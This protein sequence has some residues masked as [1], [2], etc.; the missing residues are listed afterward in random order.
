MFFCFRI[1]KGKVYNLPKIMIRIAW[2]MKCRKLITESFIDIHLILDTKSLLLK[3]SNQKGDLVRGSY[4]YI[5]GRTGSKGC[6]F[7][8]D[9]L[10]RTQ[11]FRP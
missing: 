5:N 10:R 2:V 4:N 7:K 8:S 3:I 11:C 6:L 9:F 1:C